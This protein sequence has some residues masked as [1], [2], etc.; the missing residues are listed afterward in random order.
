[1]DFNP[2]YSYKNGVHCMNMR[3]IKGF[4]SGNPDIE[5]PKFGD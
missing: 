2:I 3:W 1:M 4:H 5:I